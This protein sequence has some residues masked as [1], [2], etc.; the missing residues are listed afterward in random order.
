MLRYITLRLFFMVVTLFIIVS[1]VQ[2]VG[3]L[4]NTYKWTIVQYP[5]STHAM[6]A[7]E[8]YKIWLINVVTRWDFGQSYLFGRPSWDLIVSGMRITIILNLVVYFFF[9]IFGISLGILTAIYKDTWFDRIVVNLTVVM[10]SVPIYI[11]AML[12][13]LI[14]GYYLNLLLP[15]YPLYEQTPWGQFKAFIIPCLSLGMLP[16][17]NVIRI[18]RAEVL[19][20]MTE[21]FVFV[22]KAKGL[23]RRKI[24][25]KH[26]FRHVLSAII[27][28]LTNMFVI[29]L[30]FSFFLEIVYQ[31]RGVGFYLYHSIVHKAWD[32]NTVLFDMANVTVIALFYSSFVLIIGFINNLLLPIIDPRI[33]M[34]YQRK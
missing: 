2:Y 1:L 34:G 25:F 22:L 32:G 9:S 30:S 24:I 27:P 13:I 5:L 29:V 19:D 3:D 28:E 23:P 21:E 7:W 8:N 12:M 15:M 14:F 6:W 4:V 20:E 17:A 33:V 18:T 16:L 10:G 26:V 31:T 11:T